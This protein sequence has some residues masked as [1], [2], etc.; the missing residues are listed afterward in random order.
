MHTV[1][2]VNIAYPEIFTATQADADLEGRLAVGATYSE[3]DYQ[4]YWAQLSASGKG[5][6]QANELSASGK[7]A[8]Q[9]N[10]SHKHRGKRKH[11]K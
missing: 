7:G 5:T 6:A 4:L 1:R 8:G 9:A 11:R 2:C 10:D 3:T